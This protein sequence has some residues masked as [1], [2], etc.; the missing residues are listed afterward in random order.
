[1]N[2]RIKILIAVI[3]VILLGYFLNLPSDPAEKKSFFEIEQESPNSFK[4]TVT[5]SEE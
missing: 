4:I 3:I 1:M 5:G 2:K